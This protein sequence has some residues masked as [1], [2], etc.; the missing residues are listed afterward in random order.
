MVQQMIFHHCNIH[1]HQQLDLEGSKGPETRPKK[2]SNKLL[3]II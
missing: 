2:V 3:M 1:F